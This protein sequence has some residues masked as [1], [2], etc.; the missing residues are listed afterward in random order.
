VG[1]L[2]RLGALVLDIVAIMVVALVLG[3][4]LGALLGVAAARSAS[5][6]LPWWVGAFGGLMAGGALVAKAVA[7]AYMLTEAFTGYTPA[8]LLLGIRV[9]N[10]DGTAAASHTLF[11]RAAL[12][13]VSEV[14][15]V[16]A[17]VFGIQQLAG[18]GSFLGLIFLLG[19]LLAL[20]PDHQAL[21]DKIAG[22]AVFPK[23]LVRVPGVSDPQARPDTAWWLK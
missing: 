14:G 12:K 4:P 10:A 9:A 1:F 3:G 6:D 16:L 22:T 15:A 11:T 13:N 21:H 23:N 8:K 7:L 20:L 19:C 17:L 5:P 18:L 2:V